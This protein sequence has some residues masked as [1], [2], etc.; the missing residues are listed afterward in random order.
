MLLIVSAVC[1]YIAVF[2]S[3]A[4]P[5]NPQAAIYVDRLTTLLTAGAATSAA[6][7]LAVLLKGY[8]R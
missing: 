8:R 1:A 6:F 3:Y 4:P 2:V 7:G 5:I